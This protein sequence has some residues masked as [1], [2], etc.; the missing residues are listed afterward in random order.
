MTCAS[1]LKWLVG[2]LQILTQFEHGVPVERGCLSLPGATLFFV[3][4][5]EG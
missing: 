3:N 2:F 1:E 5:L 4:S